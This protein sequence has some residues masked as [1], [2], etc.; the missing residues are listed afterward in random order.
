MV[1]VTLTY[2]F[3][4][5]FLAAVARALVTPTWPAVA[6]AGV[7]A[8]VLVLERVGAGVRNLPPRVEALETLGRELS[9]LKPKILQ[10]LNRPQGR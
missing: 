10:I 4:V 8:L 3:P 6:T 7:V 1:G 5:L 2:L 9:E